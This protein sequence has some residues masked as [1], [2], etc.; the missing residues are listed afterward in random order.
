MYI[1]CITLLLTS[2]IFDHNS[3]VCTCKIFTQE[4]FY[5][6]QYLCNDV[7]GLG[8]FPVA[9]YLTNFLLIE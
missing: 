9:K 5:V 1:M 6:A 7:Y 8:K 4:K 3:S 2:E